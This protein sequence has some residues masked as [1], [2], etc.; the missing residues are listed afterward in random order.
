MTLL[1]KKIYAIFIA[2]SVVL[3]ESRKKHFLEKK[4][5]TECHEKLSYY[6]KSLK[7]LTKSEEK[8]KTEYHNELSYCKKS[9][10]ELTK[11]HEN[12][13]RISSNTDPSDRKLEKRFCQ[14]N[15]FQL[16]VEIQ[17]DYNSDVAWKLTDLQSGDE[18][19]KS[20]K[21]NATN[22]I[23]VDKKCLYNESYQFEIYDRPI[24]YGL[25][26]N[27]KINSQV[28]WGSYALPQKTI[29]CSFDEDCDDGN[30]CTYDVCN[31][32]TKSCQHTL[33]NALCPSVGTPLFMAIRV[34]AQ[35]RSTTS[36]SHELSNSLYKT[37]DS[38]YSMKSQ[39]MSCSFNLFTPMPF[40]GT[41]SSGA[42]VSE[43]VGEVTLNE[44]IVGKYV[45]YVENEVLDAAAA[46]YGD[47]KSQF[48]YIM[49]FLPQ[50]TTLAGNADWKAFAYIN[51]QISVYNDIWSNYPNI[52][53]HEIGHNI[54]L[55]HSHDEKSY[56]D[57][58][59]LMGSSPEITDG[60]K[61]C[62]NAAKSWQLGWYY[63]SVYTI[64]AEDIKDQYF[65]IIGITDYLKAT[66][67]YYTILKIMNS[68]DGFDYYIAFNAKAGFTNETADGINKVLISRRVSGLLYHDSTNLVRLV[69][70]NE[71]SINIRSDGMPIKIYVPLI[72]PFPLLHATIRVGLNEMC[73]T[74]SQ[75]EDNDSCTIDSCGNLDEYGL[76]RCSFVSKE[77]S[78][79]GTEVA[80]SYTTNAYPKDLSLVIMNTDNNRQI[81]KSELDLKANTAYTTSKC[82]PYA[83][84]KFFVSYNSPDETASNITYALKS[85]NMIVFQEDT[86][87][88]F[89]VE[90]A[91]TVCSSDSDCYDHDG[92]TIDSCD[93]TQALCNNT[94]FEKDTCDNCTKIKVEL[95]MDNYPDETKWSIIDSESKVAVLSGDP[96]PIMTLGQG[97]K[98]KNGR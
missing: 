6:K 21:Y 74:D 42:T 43:G 45:T 92:C 5:K 38:H 90:D 79:C 12:L 39:F 1:S 22:K 52:H 66:T 3:C 94:A 28:S 31:K 59:C 63:D 46:K 96:Y 23:Y 4:I 83:N 48:N 8:I 9:L 16:S 81:I 91:F 54:G 50:G 33:E 61:K 53:L 60:P 14:D 65:N 93:N 78:S 26:V 30:A 69:E 36:S 89:E 88:A 97:R 57:E 77:C 40:S 49:L 70:K 24:K 44:N 18:V 67:S 62:F 55:S 41:T 32:E 72:Y 75:C 35:D 86:N 56:G 73:T 37:S 76:G 68:N 98:K 87:K 19:W 11:S 47:L 85:N 17:V 64:N 82:L 7:E 20:Q 84:Y 15:Q 95:I 29:I 34:E 25:H 58:S 51:S 80:L 10:T 13:K 2:T 27:S 71:Y